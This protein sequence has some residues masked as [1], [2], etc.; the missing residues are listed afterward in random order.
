LDLSHGELAVFSDA[1]SEMEATVSSLETCP[2]LYQET[3][4]LRRQLGRIA[5]VCRAPEDGAAGECGGDPKTAARRLIGL[6]PLHDIFQNPDL[7]D[8]FLSEL[9]LALA[10]E[11]TSSSRRDRQRKGIA[12]AKAQGVRFGAPS[13]PLPENFH[14]AHRAWRAGQCSMREAAERCGMP[15]TT[16]YNAV[17]R[18]EQAA[19][20]PDSPAA[21]DNP[22]AAPIRLRKNRPPA[23]VG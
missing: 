16:F 14:E 12:Q 21:R 19:E 7:A 17:R 15:K 22:P 23:Q 1:I 13:R 3:A 9:L 5:S 6:L 4:A 8:A 18:T 10:R 20:P 2:E 11:S